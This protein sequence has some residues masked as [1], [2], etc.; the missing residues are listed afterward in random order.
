MTLHVS[1]P[2]SGAVQR[3]L[4]RALAESGLIR[5]GTPEAYAGRWWRAAAQEAVASR[6]RR[7]KRHLLAEGSEVPYAR[8]P[9]KTRGATRA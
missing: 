8:S 4:E 7:F 2:V 9:R 3:A 1:P 6:P 5:D